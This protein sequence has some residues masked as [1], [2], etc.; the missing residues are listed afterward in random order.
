[1]SVEDSKQISIEIKLLQQ[2]QS[3]AEL[4]VHALGSYIDSEVHARIAV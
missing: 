3:P 1:M 2:R 4:M